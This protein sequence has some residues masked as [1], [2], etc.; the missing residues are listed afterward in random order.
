MWYGR[1]LFVLVLQVK[2]FDDFS[3]AHL[4]FSVAV[5]SIGS[6]YAGCNALL[7]GGCKT[8]PHSELHS[9]SAGRHCIGTTGN[10]LFIVRWKCN[11]SF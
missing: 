2:F 8:K 3:R 1:V 6:G 11:R 5:S 9:S 4:L 10:E 7:E